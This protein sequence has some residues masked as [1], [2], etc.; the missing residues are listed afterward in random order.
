MRQQAETIL[1]R[2]LHDEND[3]WRVRNLLIETYP[4]T[5]LSFN[6]EIRRWDGSRFHDEILNWQA[7]IAGRIQLWET[8]AGRLVA[9]VNPDGSG[10]A[11]LQLHPDFRELEGEMLDW[12]EANLAAAEANGSRRLEVFVNEY[13]AA[14]QKLLSHRG[15]VR[16]ADNG[17][18]RRLHLAGHELEQ[19][20]IA[21]GYLLRTVEPQNL[22][23]CQRIADLLNAA[24]N[25]TFHTGIEVQNFTRLAPCYRADLDFVAVAPDGAF[26]AY[27]GVAYEEVNR[28]ATFE[29]VCTHPEHRRHGLART[30]MLEGLQRL[31]AL[32]AADV[33]VETG[34]MIPANRLYDSIGFTEASKGYVWR[35]QFAAQGS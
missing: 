35:K 17:V 20:Q 21:P 29:P 11:H 8:A 34:D 10:D 2:P 9:A 16:T 28:H 14:R 27:V 12:A 31:A 24:F 18:S 6:W 19:P 25:R 7:R 5:P 1:T 15:Y 4:T 13:D 22:A 3:F 33:T 30:L 23:D 32:G 26:A